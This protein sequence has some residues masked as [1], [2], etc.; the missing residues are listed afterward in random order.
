MKQTPRPDAINRLSKKTLTSLNNEARYSLILNWWGIDESDIEFSL[1]SKEIQRQILLNDEP[2]K[3][4]QNHLYDE[5]ILIALSSE[6]KGVTNYFL[7]ESMIEME[8]GEYEVYGDV[9][10]LETCPCCGYRTLSS[11]VN[12]D[13]CGLCN[14]ED[15]GVVNPETYSNPNYMTLG[16]AREKFVKNMGS[17]PLG[18]WAK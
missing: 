15:N 3:D 16:K 4:V 17:L 8:L 6:Y 2:P 18:K 14:W 9:E 7:S 12:Y 10:P 1:F 13:I 11:K 5:L